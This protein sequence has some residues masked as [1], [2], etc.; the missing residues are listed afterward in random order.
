MNR[1]G[2]L[3]AGSG[4]LLPFA[5]RFS[6]SWFLFSR[7]VDV[8]FHRI[9]RGEVHRPSSSGAPVIFPAG[10]TQ[11]GRL[12]RIEADVHA[13]AGHDVERHQRRRDPGVLR[14][15]ERN[16]R[17]RRARGG[18]VLEDAF[19]RIHVVRQREGH[20]FAALARRMC[21]LRQHQGGIPTAAQNAK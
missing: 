16:V 19:D 5:A 7:A 9:G 21:N 8:L 1:G 20:A 13:R 18:G 3:I 11:R 14:R 17:E 10:L 15:E 6:S 12:L 4:Q 2:D